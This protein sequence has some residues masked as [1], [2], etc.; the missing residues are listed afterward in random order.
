MATYPYSYTP[1]VTDSNS[2]MHGQLLGSSPVQLKI[3]QDAD[4]SLVSINWSQMNTDQTWAGDINHYATPVAGAS[5]STQVVIG[6]LF[7]DSTT[8]SFT[9]TL[10]LN[11]TGT[12]QVNQRGNPLLGNILSPVISP[13]F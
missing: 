2:V 12:V 8:T 7:S 13:L 4:P 9:V 6:V 1:E 3:N 10:V 5:G 11:A